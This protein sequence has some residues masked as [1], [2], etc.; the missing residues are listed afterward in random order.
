MSSSDAKFPMFF[1][2]LPFLMQNFL[3]FC[4]M[5]G[6]TVPKPFPL[7]MQDFL[8]FSS[9]LPHQ[10]CP[11]VFIQDFPSSDA[12]FPTSHIFGS[13]LPKI[14]GLSQDFPLLMQIFPCF[15]HI[16]GLTA[17]RIFR[18]HRIFALLMQHLPHAQTSKQ[19][20]THTHN[21]AN[22]ICKNLQIF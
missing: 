6:P 17:P 8:R 16:F 1:Q 3:H 13:T 2:G 21:G 7:L 10:K 18:F 19:T 20:H 5:L 11:W 12:N 14:V 22:R 15:F 4:H 9:F